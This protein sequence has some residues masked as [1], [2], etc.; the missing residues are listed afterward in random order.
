[1]AKTRKK[2][3]SPRQRQRQ[4]T[5]IYIKRTPRN[6]PAAPPLCVASG[7]VCYE[8]ERACWDAIREQGN[9]HL[10]VPYRCLDCLKH[11]QTSNEVTC[12]RRW[13]EM[14]RGF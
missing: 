3:L 6:A 10:C 11:H 9:L 1:M 12:A 5:Q 13:R 14:E 7:K 8:T 4:A 2:K